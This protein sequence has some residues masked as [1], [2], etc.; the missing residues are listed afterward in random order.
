MTLWPKTLWG[1]TLASAVIAM[2]AAQLI[3]LVLFN[4]LIVR[5]ERQRVS[6]APAESIATLS[7]AFADAT[8]Q[9]RKNMTDRLRSSGWID[10]WRGATP[11]D[12][13]GPRPRL[14]ERVFM[15]QLADA[16]HG[17]TDFYW[18]TDHQ[19]KLW[20]H[21]YLGPEPYWISIKS[22]PQLRPTG[23]MLIC[24]LVSG[25]LA[26]IVATATARMLRPLHDLKAAAEGM[27]LSDLPEPVREDGPDDIAAVSRSFNLMTAR[28]RQADKE[29]A[30]ILAGISH[31]VRTPLAKLKL[32]FAMMKGDDDLRKS[33]DRQIDAIDRILSQFLTFAR[34]YEAE[35][36]AM[37][38]ARKLREEMSELYANAGVVVVDGPDGRIPCRPEAT[39]RAVMNLVE[40]AVRYGGRPIEL[41]TVRDASGWTIRVRD[42]G[43]GV[44]PEKLAA[45]REPFVRGDAARGPDALGAGLG[46]AIADKVA[47]L[48]GGRLDL[49]NLSDG[50]EAR[51]VLN[52]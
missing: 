42:H 32:A 37:L 3:S 41:S 35:A 24:I 38:S 2:V 21:V 10:V 36:P 28:L 6:R 52:P 18:R 25:A 51:L 13:S 49:Q 34:G 12:D 45:I 40:N 47:R 22:P 7:D 23:L 14:M 43:A 16:L 9:Q 48:H 46:L 26:A 17:Q 19:R 39:R 1:Q 15:R 8:P 50:F 33:A 11:P 29:R 31:D 20:V 30:L 44:P 4:V 27:S 5:P